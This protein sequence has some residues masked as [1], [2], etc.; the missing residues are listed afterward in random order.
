MSVHW[1]TPL[2]TIGLS[3]PSGVCPPSHRATSISGSRVCLV[4][5][6]TNCHRH[7]VGPFSSHCGHPARAPRA[8]AASLPI[9]LS[10][11]CAK[12]ASSGVISAP[13]DLAS[14]SK[15]GTALATSSSARL[16][17][18]P[19]VCQAGICIIAFLGFLMPPMPPTLTSSSSERGSGSSGF[20]WGLSCTSSALTSLFWYFPSLT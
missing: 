18:S 3:M 6:S 15:S 16:A 10:L 9:L 8:F 12:S 11:V 1:K 2:G 13:R 14:L 19:Q 4:T 20:Q 5:A 7:P 17:A